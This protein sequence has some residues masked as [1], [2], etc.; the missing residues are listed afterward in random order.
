MNTKR[1]LD[2]A[3]VDYAWLGYNINKYQQQQQE[4]LYHQLRIRHSPMIINC[5]PSNAPLFT[6]TVGGLT[7]SAQAEDRERERERD[8]V[9][10]I[11]REIERGRLSVVQTRLQQTLIGLPKCEINY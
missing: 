6:Q 9:R 5:I 11:V 7:Q 3:L 2:N 10:Q 4:H 1:Q 8:R